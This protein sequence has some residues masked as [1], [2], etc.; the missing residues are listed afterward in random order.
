[1][2]VTPG[3]SF[4]RYQ[5]LSPIGAGGMGEVYLAEDPS[6]E[7]KVAIKILGE[8]FNEDTE[9]LGRFVQEARSAS[10]LN[11]PNILTIFEI[12]K[13]DGTNYIVSEYVEGET[14]KRLLKHGRPQLS[15]ALDIGIQTA[16]ALS[17]AHEAG[18]VHRDIKPANI[19][20]RKD[21]LVKVVDF[22]IAKIVQ[23][24]FDPEVHGEAPTRALIGTEPGMMI[25]TPRYMSPEQARG[26]PVDQRSDIFSLGLVLYELFSGRRAFEGD[27][28]MDLVSSILRDEPP[29]ISDSVPNF[30]A[31]L[32]K[33][34]TKALRKDRSHRY[35]N[36]RDLMI[37]LEDVRDDLKFEKKQ[38]TKG[39]ATRKQKIH[40]TDADPTMGTGKLTT[41]M[42]KERRFS[43]LHAF[44]FIALALL[45]A[46]GYWFY[47]S[48]S[49]VPEA[50]SKDFKIEELASWSS[51][52]GELFSSAKFSPDGRLIAFSST[53]SGTKDIWVTQTN[54]KEAIQI[55]KDDFSNTD[56]VW[57]P[58]GSEIAYFSDKGMSADGSGT[59]TGVWKISALGGTPRAVGP[60]TDGSSRL[61]RWTISGKIIYESKGV[62]YSMDSSNGISEKMADFAPGGANV[63]WAD[64]SNDEKTVAYVTE[65]DGVWK[66]LEKDIENGTAA[67][68]VTRD[69]R[70]TDVSWL[71]EQETYFFSAAENDVDQVFG[72][73]KG[74]GQAVQITNSAT[75]NS[76]AHASPDGKSL[77][78]SSSREDSNLW[79]AS[80]T[81]SGESPV[82]QGISSELWPAVSP[83][84]KTLAFQSIR[85]LDRG[86]KLTSG[87]VAVTATDRTAGAPEPLTITEDGYLPVWS[88]DGER[89]AIRRMTEKSDTLL[90]INPAGGSEMELASGLWPVGFSVSPYNRVQSSD[91]SWAPDGSAIAYISEVNGA[92]NLWVVPSGGG[93]PRAIT[94]FKTG[95]DSLACPVYSPDGDSIAF[96]SQSRGGSGEGG[97]K[98]KL[99]T[100]DV[101]TGEA[102]IRFE[103]DKVIRLIGWTEAGDGLIFAEASAFKSLPPETE[104]RDVSF[105]GG[106]PSLIANLKE[107]Y[108][109]N[110]FLSPDRKEIAYAARGGG[111]DDIWVVGSGGGPARK[112]TNNNDSE[113]Y[114]SSLA[115]APDGSFIYFGKQTRYSLLSIITNLKN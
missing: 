53:R 106:E 70:I 60:I 76:V 66:I 8:E 13:D 27:E 49:H 26:K 50:F 64:V 79:R 93:A 41:Q 20:V 80:V 87:S 69:S 62:L 95:G 68:I 2:P 35:Q 110:I 107:A 15:K 43:I 74:S 105:T 97:K 25:G 29:P 103:S 91:L 56:P 3:E 85:N 108:Y 83:D 115:W 14:V 102:K 47:D 84:G 114:F 86:D 96:Y 37:D 75:G 57:S 73:V 112:L 7:R 94:S 40:L 39:D 4:G 12:T 33:I 61:R 23:S 82:V 59:R 78:F 46:A 72:I 44:G 88:P 65:D 22:G 90:T 31:D 9:R 104:V 54:S 81:G 17:A 28:T 19:M 6:L 38:G 92:A 10:A 55:T 36:I 16:S 98:R 21:G 89:L 34:A 42:V 77:I 100:V 45:L 52:P 5:I 24:G 18:I 32:E 109:Y 113:T 67:E 48:Y 71:P 30:P 63:L 111:L 51:A 1:M 11:H 99:W 58:D 101:G